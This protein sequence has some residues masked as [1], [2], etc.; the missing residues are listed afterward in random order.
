[1][2]DETPIADL[3][4]DA[5]DD[6]EPADRLAAIQSRTA[7]VTAARRWWGVAGGV[8]LATAATVALVAALHDEPMT[9]DHRHDHGHAASEP[10][11]D[12]VLVPVYFVGETPRGPRL[13]REF[14]HAA[15][16]DP[17]QAALDRLQSPPSD[18][19]LRSPWDRD[20]FATAT[21]HDDR[22]DVEVGRGAGREMSAAALPLQGLVYTLQ[23]AAGA[24][25]PV[26]IV[27]HGRPVVEPLT[28]RPQLDVLSHVMINDPSEG[29]AVHR[30]FTARGA[31]S[32]F[33]ANVPWELR[34][35]HGT[36]VRTGHATASGSGDRLYPWAT[37]VDVSR[38]PYG[39]YTFV[40]RTDDPSDGAAEPDSDTRTIIVR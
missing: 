5:V 25:L 9:T 20:T 1:M 10:M 16:T 2:N 37:R 31:A 12:M 28:A 33:E 18:P 40:A 32:S 27:R 35:E 30:W 8:V 24:R 26:R 23:G 4:R 6:V 17:V 11:D 7:P 22:I 34:D 39:S 3:L 15:G 13:F 38:L 21:V 14:D 36:V 29:L 19:D